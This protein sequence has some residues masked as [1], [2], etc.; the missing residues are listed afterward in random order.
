[1]M[2]LEANCL[3]VAN[4]TPLFAPVTTAS[5][6]TNQ[7][8]CFKIWIV[9]NLWV[10]NW[11]QVSWRKWGKENFGVPLH[12]SCHWSMNKSCCKMGFYCTFNDVNYASAI[13]L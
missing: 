11:K 8:S 12:C 1:L 6:E 13:I 2:P 4:P 9:K 10:I 3:H 5:L 7:I